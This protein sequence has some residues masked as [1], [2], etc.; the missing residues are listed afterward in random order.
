[1]HTNDPHSF[2]LN[3]YERKIIYSCS[4]KAMSVKELG[5]I[6]NIPYSGGD[7]KRAMTRLLQLK[8]VEYTVPD[9]HRSYS[10]RYKATQK[11]R[12]AIR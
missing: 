3:D 9:F 4:S 8:L 7:M 2:I 1:M 11:G 12:E 6:L 5:N 10:Q